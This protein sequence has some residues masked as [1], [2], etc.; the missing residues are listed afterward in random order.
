[1]GGGT[2]GGHGSILKVST[3]GTVT[4][5]TGFDGTNGAHPQAPLLRAKD[6]MFYGTTVNG[7]AR[8]GFSGVTR[9]TD[10]NFYGT[11]QTAERM[12]AARFSESPQI[13]F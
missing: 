9:G 13:E 4:L 3:N 11:T 6:G 12:E 8:P 7:G 5:L 2:N 10:G 1:M